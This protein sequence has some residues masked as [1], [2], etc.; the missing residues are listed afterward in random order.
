MKK[1]VW[2]IAAALLAT[3]GCST[4]ENKPAPQPSATASQQAL[5]TANPTATQQNSYDRGFA[6]YYV[7][8]RRFV[9][10][11]WGNAN[12]W[13]ANAQRDGYAVGT[14][15]KKGAIACSSRG[16]YGMVAY[17]EDV[18]ADGTQVEISAMA[19]GPDKWNV[20]TYHTLP[21]DRFTYIY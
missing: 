20:V 11:Y 7:A 12:M 15:P 6:T 16:N 19:Y 3:A 9:P 17:V 4:G 14:T 8:T 18:S 1:L 13:Y 21:A 5:P 2:L 10:P